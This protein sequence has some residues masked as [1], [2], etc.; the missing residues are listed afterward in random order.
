MCSRRSRPQSFD[1]RLHHQA[2]SLMSERSVRTQY[3]MQECVNLLQ[4]NCKYTASTLIHARD[5]TKCTPHE[6]CRYSTVPQSVTHVLPATLGNLP[7]AS[8]HRAQPCSHLHYEYRATPV[9]LSRWWRCSPKLPIPSGTDTHY[10]HGGLAPASR[11]PSP[12]SNASEKRN[13]EPQKR[14]LPAE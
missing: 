6:P 7:T 10:D 1:R 3:A 14:K 13:A 9:Q 2:P 5:R 11:P 4:A 8:A 12:P